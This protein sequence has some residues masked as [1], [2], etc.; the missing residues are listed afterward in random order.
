MPSF[1]N[2]VQHGQNAPPVGL[3]IYSAERNKRQTTMTDYTQSGR[4]CNS[5]R[6]DNLFPNTGRLIG[7]ALNSDGDNASANIR[8][9]RL[10]LQPSTRRTPSSTNDSQDATTVQEVERLYQ[11]SP[12]RRNSYHTQPYRRSWTDSRKTYQ[13]AA[14]REY[15]LLLA[16]HRQA[17]HLI[18]VKY[19]REF[20][21]QK[22]RTTWL[23][24]KASLQQQGII[25]FVVVE[26]TTR[27]HIFQDGRY[28]DYPVNQIH[29]HFLVDS[30]LSK[31]QLRKIFNRS[32]IDTG[33]L[34]E[35]FEVHYEAIP[36]RKTFEHKCRYILKYG[37]FSEQAILF[38]PRNE[39]G[40]LDK[41]CSIL[42]PA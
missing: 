32:C 5:V 38:R 2:E 35:D 18:T 39:I 33:L 9:T 29:Y 26:V 37:N 31:R 1:A 28:R 19:F 11:R 42:F 30:D 23:K 10:P 24:L 4:D 15:D 14:K 16:N 6:T 13:N 17:N 36:D 20:S 3:T 12:R 27:R 21:T 22:I 8:N 41:I 34:K 25:S 40:K 7:V